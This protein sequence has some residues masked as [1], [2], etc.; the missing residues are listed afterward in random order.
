MNKC[1]RMGAVLR[2]GV[3][4]LGVLWMSGVVTGP[5]VGS[6]LAQD[7]AKSTEVAPTEKAASADEVAVEADFGMDSIFSRAWRGGFVV[8]TVLLT[9]VLM[10][11]ATW[12]IA[13]AKWISL[14]KVDVVSKEFVKS[15]WDSRSLNDLHGRLRD[16][17]YSPMREIFRT[18]YSELV[19]ANQLRDQTT[20]LPVA[21]NAAVENL[22]RSLTKAKN[23]ERNRLERY[24]TVLAISASAAPFIGLF[25]TV[26]GIMG[27]FEGIAR[28]GST[29][30]AA[31]APGISEALIATAFGL[32]AAIPA[33]IGYNIA[34]SQL[35]SQSA[36]M[37][38]FISDF[39]NIVERYLVSDRSK[40]A[41]MTA[42]QS[43]EKA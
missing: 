19:R 11:I 38:G 39:L 26:W 27:A 6:A 34:A 4:L 13:I 8:F 31:V 29:S 3:A 5:W 18:G 21:V 25:G 9:L 32:A 22:T 40:A 2:V 17:K 35:R 12:A 37:D 15:F 41:G 33:A 24:L 42:Q 20:S 14:R 43:T 23:L 36:R 7:K 10:S 16:F 28:S 1:S 30:L